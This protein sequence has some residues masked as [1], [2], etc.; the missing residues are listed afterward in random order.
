ML[1]VSR[2]MGWGRKLAIWVCL[3]LPVLALAGNVRAS[4]AT[5]WLNEVPV[6]TFLTKNAGATPS[7]RAASVVKVLSAGVPLNQLKVVAGTRDAK[8]VVGGQVL[9]RATAAEAK[10]QRRTPLALANHWAEKIR[11]AHALPAIQLSANELRLPAAATRQIHVVGSAARTFALSNSDPQVVQVR[12]DGNQIF[13]KSLRKG[14]AMI[15][16]TAGKEQ[17]AFQ[18]SVLPFAAQLP[19][20]LVAEVTGSPASAT[21]VLG[22]LRSTLQ[23]KLKV[24]DGSMVEWGSFKGQALG[25]GRSTKVIVPVKVTGPNAYPREGNVEINVKNVAIPLKAETELWY[26]NHPENLTGTGLLFA[27][28]LEPDEAA[29]LLYHHLNASS[30]P[31]VVQGLLENMSDQPARVLIIPGDGEPDKDPVRTGAEAGE[32]FVRAYV[33]GS[34]EVVQ[35]P[36]RSALPIALRRLGPG[37]TIS[38]LCYLRCLSGESGA[39]LFR[40]EAVAPASLDAKWMTST[41][42]GTPWHLAGSRPLSKYELSPVSLSEHVY[43]QPFKQVQAD[44]TVGG[45]FTF[46]RIGQKPIASSNDQMALDGNF[47]VVYTIKSTLSNPTDKLTEV[48]MIFEAS[49]GYSS[50]IFV[51]NGK[52]ERSPMLQSKQ[53]YKVRRLRLAPGQTMKIVTQ[54]IPLSGSS[55]PATITFRPSRESQ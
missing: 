44:Y 52:V 45:P 46:I 41:Q 4:G 18:V 31:L 35:I 15:K 5:V 3:C 42:L 36:P 12:R 17:A 10:A 16:A 24:V 55:Y 7:A 43:P 33:S 23:T 51:L 48:D 20:R 8:L 40:A 11:L 29:R 30:I 37:Q 19:Q 47:G 26:C 39:L 9:A 38:G 2:T 28:M 53:E 25:Q 34:G 49:A 13:V 1:L 22:A 32:K 27:A 14:S 6:V 54:T 50:A 21:T